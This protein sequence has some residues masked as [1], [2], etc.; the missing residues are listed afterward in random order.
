MNW[1]KY[2]KLGWSWSTGWRPNYGGY[3]AQ[4]VKDLDQKDLDKPVRVNGRRVYRT[5]ITEGGKTISEA[6]SKVQQRID[7]LLES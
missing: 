4:A 7:S 3:Y 2:E 1:Y 6:E 5:C